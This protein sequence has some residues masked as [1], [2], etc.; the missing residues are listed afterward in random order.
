MRVYRARVQPETGTN[1]LCAYV[2]LT[3]VDPRMTIAQARSIRV[4]N[5]RKRTIEYPRDII[6]KKKMYVKLGTGR[7]VFLFIDGVSEDYNRAE[8]DFGGIS[9]WEGQD[10]SVIGSELS[11]R[12]NHRSIGQT[13]TVAYADGLT[14]K[15]FSISDNNNYPYIR[16]SGGINDSLLNYSDIMRV[17]ALVKCVDME[18]GKNNSLLAKGNPWG[19]GRGFDFDYTHATKEWRMNNP[20][21]GGW[22]KIISRRQDLAEHI[23]ILIQKTPTEVIVSLDGVE[24]KRTAETKSFIRIPSNIRIGSTLTTS[25]AYWCGLIAELTISRNITTPEYNTAEALM[26]KDQSAFWGEWQ[27]VTET[28]IDGLSGQK[29]E[30][31]KQYL[32]HTHAI[33]GVT[34]T[35]LHHHGTVGI[36]VAEQAL[37]RTD[38]LNTDK[39]AIIA[40][41]RRLEGHHNIDHKRE[42]FI[43][44]IARREYVEI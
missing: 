40:E 43:S 16:T 7:W 15:A 39:Q 3:R 4:Y 23:V 5:D 38:S 25:S 34:P 42:Q 33:T 31:E 1:G 13:G 10:I 6:S 14:G 35:D 20:R 27:D 28:H 22:K 44:R 21:V 26:L 17:R 36:G 8:T 11:D 12:S 24:N 19:G 18:S 2:D 37:E 41:H 29:F 30:L 32:E 9:A